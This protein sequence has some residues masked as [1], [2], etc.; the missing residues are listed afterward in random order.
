[1]T[2]LAYLLLL[3]AVGLL[4][5]AVYILVGFRL[6]WARLLDSVAAEP[7]LAFVSGVYTLLGIIAVLASA[8]FF[9]RWRHAWL[10]AMIVQG[11]TLLVALISYFGDHPDYV[12]LVL[13]Y[14]IV[15]VL[16]LNYYEVRIAFD[17]PAIERREA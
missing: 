14:G 1:V 6:S 3:Q 7:N 4:A 8:G 10:H 5:I 16:Y 12:Y 9:G 17:Q 13:V 15:M 2:V 11:A